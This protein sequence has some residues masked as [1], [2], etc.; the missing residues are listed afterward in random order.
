MLATR[1]HNSQKYSKHFNVLEN[2]YFTLFRL[3]ARTLLNFPGLELR[4]LKI[5][6]ICLSFYSREITKFTTIYK[7]FLYDPKELTKLTL[8]TIRREIKVKLIKVFPN[9]DL[10][11]QHFQNCSLSNASKIAMNILRNYAEGRTPY[12]ET[13]DWGVTRWMMKFYLHLFHYYETVKIKKH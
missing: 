13:V 10:V 3:F 4:N 2:R 12:K 5:K 7:M 8:H 9:C 6:L 1:R 11:V